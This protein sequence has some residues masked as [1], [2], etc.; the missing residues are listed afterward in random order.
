MG[1]TELFELK[2]PLASSIQAVLDN[3][4]YAFVPKNN[5]F[6]A[7]KIDFERYS[8]FVRLFNLA[9]LFKGV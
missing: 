1:A 3:R 2:K 6:Y 4:F 8:P 9:E 5:R 7:E